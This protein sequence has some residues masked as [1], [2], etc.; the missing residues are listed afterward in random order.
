MDNIQ[1]ISLLFVQNIE[2][3][4]SGINDARKRRIKRMLNILCRSAVSS[5]SL[6]FPHRR[7]WKQIRHSKWFEKTVLQHYDDSRWK[8]TF[9]IN[10]STFTIICD[11]L[12]PHLQKKKVVRDV[13]SVEVGIAVM[14][15]RLSSS[16]ELRNIAELFGMARSTVCVIVQ[17]T[18]R[19]VVSCYM[20]VPEG[21][22]VS[23]ATD[24]F[25]GVCGLPGVLGALDGCHIPI[26][27]PIRNKKDF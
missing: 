20:E 18:T 1:I 12:R 8:E 5:L 17:Q 19:V 3:A 25:F 23:I 26:K 21:D 9:R 11:F 13:F 14:L 4:L 7:M 10:R 6:A 24:S 15:L 27:A 16:S 2:N 22:E